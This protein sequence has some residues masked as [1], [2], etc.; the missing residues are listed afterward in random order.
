[1]HKN[2]YPHFIAANLTR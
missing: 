2:V 1:M